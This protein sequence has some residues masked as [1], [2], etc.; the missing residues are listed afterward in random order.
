MN[1]LRRLE[2]LPG[3]WFGWGI[4]TYST[5][6]VEGNTHRQSQKTAV[7]WPAFMIRLFH[8][9][10][11]ICSLTT[12]VSAQEYRAFARH[13][14]LEQGLPHRQVNNIIQDRRGFIWAATHAGVARFDGREF[15]VFNKTENGLAGDLVEW[16]A[17]DAD[18]YIWACRSGPNG[19]LCVLDPVLGTVVPAATWFKKHP[20]PA[21]VSRWW[22]A[23]VQMA[24]GSLLIS[25]REPGG[26]LRYHPD[27]GWSSIDLPDCEGFQFLK[28]TARQTVWGLWFRQGAAVS[29]VEIDTQGKVLKRIMPKPGGIFAP[30][31]GGAAN[32]DHF[33]LL[34]MAPGHQPIVWEFDGYGQRRP[35]PRFT[36]QVFIAQ[37]SRLEK[38]RLEVQF[39]LI[40]DQE[41][42]ILL[43]VS[44][45]YPEIDPQQYCDYLLDYNGNVWFATTFGLIVVEI[46][47]NNFRRL[48][49]DENARG[50]R[51]NACRGLL[52]KNGSLLVNLETFGQGRYRVNPQTGAAERLPGMCGIGIAAGAEGQVWTDCH[53]EGDTWQT[54][55]LFKAR[56]DGQL[57]GQR[58]LQKRDWGFIWTILEERPHRVLLGHID[59]MTVYNPEEGTAK[60]W[61]DEQFPEFNS[62]NVSWLGKDRAGRIWACTEQGLYQLNSGGGVAARYWSGGNGAHYLPYDFIYHFYEDRDGIFWLGTAG[63]GLIRWD[64]KAEP[65]RHTRVI[66]RESGLLNGVVYAVYEDRH[67]HLWL[68]TDYGLVQ[69][70]KENLQVRHTWLKADGLTHNE[71]NRISH[72]QSLDGA[73]YFGGLNGVT[74]LHPDDFYQPE[75]PDKNNLP[76]VVSAFSILNSATGRLE[77]NMPEL[78]KS[79]RITIHPGDRYVQLEFALLEYFEPEKVT[80]TWKLEGVI[81]DWEILQEPV[82]RLSGLPYGDH[83]LRIR[84]Q[85]AD[86]SWAKNELDIH[87][88]VLPPFY[89]R[90]WFFLFSLLL[91]AA[92]IRLW[93][94]WRTREHRLVQ[95]RLEQ[96]VNRQTT[97]IRRQAEELTQL[98]ALKSRFFANVSHELRTPLTLLLGPIEYALSEKALS[99]KSRSLLLA[100]QRNGAQLQRLV[101]EI[102]DISKL[103]AAGLEIQEQATVLFDFLHEILSNFRPVAES[104][105]IA[106]QLDYRP[107]TSW[108]LAL[109]RQKMLKILSNLLSNALKYAPKDSAVE[110]AVEKQAGAVVF[111][112][113]DAGPGIHPDDLPH[114]FDLYFQS[115][116]PERKAEGGTGIGLA[117]AR[118]LVLAM[119]GSVQAESAPGKGSVFTLTL[120]A[121]ERARASAD[122][123]LGASSHSGERPAPAS[124]PEPAI[125][126][127]L[128]H[129]LVV[130]D[131]PDLRAYLY[132]ILSPDYRLT[133]VDNGR[134]ALDVLSGGGQRPDLILSDVMMPEMDGFQLLE[135]LRRNEAWR[136]IPVIMLTA[137]A[138]SDDRLRAFR[139]G[140][141]DYIT[142]PFS[143]EELRVRLENALRNQAARRE[144][145]EMEPDAESEPAA[146][147]DA[148]LR[149]LR[150]TVLQNLSNPQFNIDDLADRMGVS[151]KT[152]YRKVRG[153]AG[154]SANQFIQEIRL[155]HT[156]NLI[157]RGEYRTLRE[158]AQAVG[159]RSADYLSRLYRE[160]FGKPPRLDR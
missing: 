17:E 12:Q 96:E 10:L 36:D 148:W 68:P 145:M 58:L 85:A 151:R 5:H 16:V 100:A 120:P 136:P 113:R 27:S 95:Q 76:L 152:L 23:P 133:L 103:R 34:E 37:H 84:A 3:V 35:A 4:D 138:G 82:L 31:K 124:P 73:L 93:L 108:T 159:L 75:N 139:I 74:A 55:S 117:L 64:P 8:Y 89:L 109:D 132:A 77:N 88:S 143:A 130:E 19:W 60:P 80:Y 13:F 42:R 72:C 119:G 79:N 111:Q 52:E 97:T 28:P 94:H 147:I 61:V 112:V 39:P 40:L 158:I 32:P 126:D 123:V 1:W 81:D 41:G 56:A 18:G 33:F 69:L 105:G 146:H 150:E 106:L 15:K 2:R 98:D 53:L 142:K 91:L 11:V 90:W 7:F 87:L 137:L 66:F 50:E 104:R 121:R 101:D 86:G 149:Q 47:K 9:A 127:P 155:L 24:D 107:D 30:K 26:V 144:W 135:T 156:R 6:R 54:L 118:E 140:I 154:L 70:D 92:G 43:D 59:G 21:P 153:Y 99:P 102:L 44:R 131:N 110:L 45:Q 116:R 71:F 157:E 57:T 83:R 49:Y 128:A 38:D 14:G 22:K 129:L 67:H 65:G 78:L 125:A 51:G 63:G 29:L 160:R 25:I 115:K 46:R 134:A 20:L 141:D 62:A 48:L 122:P 114:I